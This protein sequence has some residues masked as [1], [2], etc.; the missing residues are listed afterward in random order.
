MNLASFLAFH[1]IPSHPMDNHFIRFW[2]MLLVFLFT[3]VN[4]YE[5]LFIT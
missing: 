4:K 3:N 2:S 1:H 5:Y